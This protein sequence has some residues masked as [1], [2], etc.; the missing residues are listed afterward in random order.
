MVQPI[1][2]LPLHP[3]LGLNSK[4]ELGPTA[5]ESYSIVKNN[6]GI[7]LPAAAKPVFTLAPHIRSLNA[8]Q[9]HPDAQLKQVASQF[10]AIFL[11]MVLNEMRNSVPK[12]DL[13]GN[14]LGLDFFQS[15]SDDQLSSD[16]SSA[17]GIG[18][19]KAI[20]QKLVQ[21]QSK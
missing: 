14:S 6:D 18:I 11:R 20:Y 2:A 10:E 12:S 15:M 13:M 8:P 7:K 4:W 17:G 9:V 5:S 21:N 1:Q 19:G 16:L 3:S